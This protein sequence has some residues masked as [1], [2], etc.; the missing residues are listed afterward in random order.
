VLYSLL[1]LNTNF[2]VAPRFED[3][4]LGVAN[5]EVNLIQGLGVLSVA[6]NPSTSQC[7]GFEG[8]ASRVVASESRVG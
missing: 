7:L 1:T 3:L 6:Q 5:S 8:F 2:A 4:R